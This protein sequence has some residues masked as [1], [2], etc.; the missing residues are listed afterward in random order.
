MDIMGMLW[1]LG[2]LA[3][4]LVFGINVGIASGLANL[5]KNLFALICVSY[6]GGVLII[7]EIASLYSN[8][9]IQIIYSYNS[10]FYLIMATVMIVAGLLTI[11]E[12]KV[13]NKNTSAATCLAV[14]APC[15]CCFGSIVS[16]LIVAP[17]IGI[18]AFNLSLYVA[19]A[20]VITMIIIYFTSNY[21][22][23]F[24]KKPYPIVL[25]NF[26]LFLGAYFLL[27]SILIP[28]IASV[29][30][31]GANS[32]SISNPQYLIPV[33]VFVIVLVIVGYFIFR[34]NDNLLK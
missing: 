6:G 10:L 31:S 5:S 19:I 8:Q 3:T 24:I 28:T 14:V 30:Q 32:L 33:L 13:H 34:K 4:I 7:C 15:P 11:H 21:I 23:K 2:I 29:M 22:V 17:T 16:I 26:M 20:L 1:Q 9:I 27:S 25:G 12:W 18:G